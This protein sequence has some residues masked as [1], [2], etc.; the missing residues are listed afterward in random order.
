LFTGI[1][2]EIKAEAVDYGAVSV[3]RMGE[4]VSIDG[5]ARFGESPV[6]PVMRNMREG[7]SMLKGLVWSIS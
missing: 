6:D 3:E 1:P 5:E 7:V 2:G 4:G